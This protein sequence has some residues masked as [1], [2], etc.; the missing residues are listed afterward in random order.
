MFLI[1]KASDRAS[2]IK[3]SS[4]CRMFYNY[5]CPMIWS[6]L[7]ISSSDIYGYAGNPEL[8]SWPGG[9]ERN[10]KIHFM[11]KHVGRESKLARLQSCIRSLLVDIRGDETQALCNQPA[12][13][14]LSM[15]TALPAL[16]PLLPN[17]TSCVYDG[18]LCRET[19]SQLVRIST[20][21]CLELRADDWYLQQ[22]CYTDESRSWVWRRWSDL[23]L[24]FRVLANLNNLH[25]LKIGRLQHHEAQGLA[26]GIAR[27]RLTNL[28]IHS[29]PWISHGDPRHYLTGSKMY[30]SPLMFFFYYLARREGPSLLPSGLPSTLETI[31]LRDRFY[32][33]KEP[34]EHVYLCAARRKCRSFLQIESTHPTGEHA[35]H[36]LL[37]FGWRP[38]GEKSGHTELAEETHN[39]VAEFLYLPSTGLWK[40]A[41]VRDPGDVREGAEGCKESRSEDSVAL[42]AAVNGGKGGY[43]S[44]I[45]ERLP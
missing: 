34:M 42:R 35:C 18:V 45:M 23:I 30:A 44:I 13:S 10:G 33:V 37:A 31:I 20:L 28:E 21:K 17:L 12:V 22:G 2:Q 26:E 7:E 39:G 41:F 4:T 19:L 5:S 6:Q 27:L 38:V 8:W 3:W 24:D 32:V 14:Q 9:I 40:F 36:F 29:S 16:L 11:E 15:E 1:I 43:R 25:S